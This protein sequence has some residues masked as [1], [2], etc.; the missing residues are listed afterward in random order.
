LPLLILILFILTLGAALTIAAL[1]VN[2]RDIQFI[3]GVVLQAG[4]FLTPII[5]PLSIFSPDIQSLILLN[6][7][8]QIITAARNI[9]I[10]STPLTSMNVLYTGIT[11]LII[12]ALGIIIFTHYE[13][14]FAEKM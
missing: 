13:P 12:F 2:Y 7:I 4:F 6:P 8:A 11:T 9:I 1:N 10:Y 14:Y 5:Y 3:W